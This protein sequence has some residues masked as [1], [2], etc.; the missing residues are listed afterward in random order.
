MIQN[1]SYYFLE[2]F[3]LT[4]NKIFTTALFWILRALL[5]YLSVLMVS[6]AFVSAGLTQA[7]IEI[8]MNWISWSIPRKEKKH[9]FINGND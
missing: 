7:T 9:F 8:S 2:I 1:G 6:S 5:A 4:V 3:L